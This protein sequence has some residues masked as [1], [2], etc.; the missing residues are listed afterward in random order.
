VGFGA[1]KPEAVTLSTDWERCDSFFAAATIARCPQAVAGH[2]LLAVRIL[3]RATGTSTTNLLMPVVRETGD[4]V[5]GGQI[6]LRRAIPCSAGCSWGF[7]T[8]SRELV[9][10]IV[11]IRKAATHQHRGVEGRVVRRSRALNA[12]ATIQ[13]ALCRWAA[14]NRGKADEGLKASHKGMG[15]K[16]LGK[17]STL[18]TPALSAK[19]F[20]VAKT[21]QSLVITVNVLRRATTAFRV[22]FLLPLAARLV[23]CLNG[24]RKQID[25]GNSVSFAL[26]LRQAAQNLSRLLAKKKIKA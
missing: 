2:G 7:P 9:T 19:N 26:L 21:S 16:Y 13:S 10:A 25:F 4:G 24:K 5:D 1:E 14:V 3:V 18:A 11:E 23:E 20:H 15:R 8:I 12:N 22:R 6:S 17:S